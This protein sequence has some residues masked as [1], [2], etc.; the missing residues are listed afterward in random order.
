MSVKGHLTF[1][2]PSLR[3]EKH[4]GPRKIRGTLTLGDIGSAHLLVFMIKIHSL[5]AVAIP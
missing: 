5:Y 2:R 4:I 1:Q 3:V